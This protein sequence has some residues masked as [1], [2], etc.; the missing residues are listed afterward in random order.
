MVGGRE[1]VKDQI[2]SAFPS[3]GEYFKSEKDIVDTLRNTYDTLGSAAMDA[4]PVRDP[5]VMDLIHD[6]YMSRFW[7][8][9]KKMADGEVLLAKQEGRDPTKYELG[10]EMEPVLNAEGALVGLQPTGRNIP[11]VR[12]LDYLRRSMGDSI[13]KGFSGTGSSGKGVAGVESGLRKNLD[14]ALNRVPAYAA[15]RTKYGGEKKVQEALRIGKEDFSKLRSEEVKNFFAKS[16]K[17]GGFSD[18]EKEAFTT[19]AVQHLM[20]PVETPSTLKDFAGNIVNS[21]STRE[22]LKLILPPKEFEV[23]NAALNAESTNFKNAAKALSGNPEMARI[24]QQIEGEM[25]SSGVSPASI[26]ASAVN[27]TSRLTRYHLIL[28]AINLIHKVPYEKNRDKMYTTLANAMRETD[29]NKSIALLKKADL[30]DATNTAR[31]EGVEKSARVTGKLVGRAGAAITD[32][33]TPSA[34]AVEIAP[35]ETSGEY[36]AAPGAENLEADSAAPKGQQGSSIQFRGVPLLAYEDG[37]FSTPEGKPVSV[38]QAQEI[39]N[40]YRA[41]KK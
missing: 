19:G 29:I 14:K 11:T 37:T 27:P 23:F 24:T 39:L 25:A 18:A 41:P 28:D 5:K 12:T 40:A 30:L 6:P 4:G 3:A 2:H 36:Q 13:D 9:A 35:L 33:P 20:Q 31:N 7:L 15:Y 26:I 32:E 22:K 17:D 10:L 34:P 38:E 1:R 21:D 8:E 16:V